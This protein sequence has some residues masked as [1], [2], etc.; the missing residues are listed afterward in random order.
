MKS[1]LGKQL[2]LIIK[3]D[4]CY[5]A[6]ILETKRKAKKIKQDLEYISEVEELQEDMNLYKLFSK[7]DKITSLYLELTEK[8][9]E[10]RDNIYEFINKVTKKKRTSIGDS[11]TIRDNTVY[12][13]GKDKIAP[14]S[15][16]LMKSGMISPHIEN[17]D[18]RE[19]FSYITEYLRENRQ[20]FDI[21]NYYMIKDLLDDKVIYDIDDNKIYIDT[22]DKYD[23]YRMKTKISNNHFSGLT[24]K[25]RS[26]IKNRSYGLNINIEN[27][28]TINRNY[29][30]VE[31]ILD[32][33][34]SQLEK[35]I[36]IVDQLTSDVEDYIAPY[37]VASKI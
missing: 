21:D 10:L 3:M 24:I 29:Q 23:D 5:R 15:K 20:I 9:D 22:D 13:Y 16:I 37:L 14:I 32:Y 28:K 1:L 12:I 11:I 17:K 36:S 4:L 30:D 7:K 19:K 2:L 31:D 33:V 8:R 34:I 25:V 35:S 27:A 26:A 18:A 6:D